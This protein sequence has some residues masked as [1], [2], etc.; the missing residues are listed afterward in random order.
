VRVFTQPDAK[1]SDLFQRAEHAAWWKER[2]ERVKALVDLHGQD[3]LSDTDYAQFRLMGHFVR[4]VPD[5]L[6][7]VQDTLRPRS[8]EEL[9]HYGFDGP[10]Q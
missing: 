6:S 9:V 10:P 3:F 2:H 8:F 5:I 1:I 4:H 7:L